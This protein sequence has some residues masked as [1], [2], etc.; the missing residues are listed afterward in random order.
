VIEI[1]LLG[2][3]GMG[4]VTCAEIIVEAAYLSGNF[5]DVHAYPSFG[6]ERRGAPVQAYAKLSRREK[7]WDR[8]EIENPNILVVFDETVLNPDVVSSLRSDGI[9]VINS[10]KEPEFFTN[11]FN[12]APS[13]R[14]VVSDISKL[15]LDKNLTIDGN[16][17]INTPILGLL[18]K[19]LPELNLENLKRVVLKRMGEKLGMENYKLIENGYNLARIK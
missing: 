4:V 17:V 13:I 8:A 2:R 11:R 19:A 5:V 16:P 7:I 3:G 18:S 10:D 12:L 1:I 15:A 6:A 9:F 14:V